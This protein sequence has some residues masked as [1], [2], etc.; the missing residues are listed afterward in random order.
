MRTGY[1]TYSHS[2]RARYARALT[3]T[4]SRSSKE[5]D[6]CRL[7]AFADRD[8]S[9]SQNSLPP[10]PPVTGGS[11]APLRSLWRHHGSSLR[12]NLPSLLPPTSRAQGS[13]NMF[14]NRQGFAHTHTPLQ[15]SLT[16]FERKKKNNIL[17]HP[18]SVKMGH[19][20]DRSTFRIS[21][22]IITSYWVTPA[23]CILLTGKTTVFISFPCGKEQYTQL[24]FL[25]WAFN[26]WSTLQ[27]V[28]Y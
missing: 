19:S 28:Y 13:G 15:C 2:F 16:N 8:V 17:L 3:H 26:Y 1:K 24:P 12:F 25:N 20:Q 7:S 4:G 18:C 21:A 23:Q 9:T 6:S 5:F 11:M 22:S 27:Y 14:Q 10:P